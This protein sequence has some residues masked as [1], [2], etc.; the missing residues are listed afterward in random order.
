MNRN[1]VEDWV[2]STDG[3]EEA[4]L[5]LRLMKTSM[6][7]LSLWNLSGP[8]MMVAVHRAFGLLMLMA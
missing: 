1:I 8:Q 5:I 2:E 6:L 3:E 4:M 7:R